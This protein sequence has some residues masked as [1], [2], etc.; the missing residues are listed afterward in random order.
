MNK[1]TY[2][3]TTPIYY[4]SNYLHIG[5]AYCT[6]AT[7][8]AARYKKLRGYDVKFLT[9]T[10]DHGQKIERT[11][12]E[13]GVTPMEYVDKIV[14][15]T[16]DLWKLMD[17]EYDYFRRTTDKDHEQAI[18]KI[19]KR[20]YDQGD[21][22]KGSYEGWY[23]T[24]CETF[25]TERQLVD[26]KCPD[27]GRGVEIVQ[28][29]CYFL[30]LSKY[31]DRLMK[32]IDDNPDFIQPVSRKNEMVNNFL[33]P[34][35]EDLCVSRTS[36]TWGVQVD[37]DPKHVVYVWVDALPNYITALGFSG[38]DESDFKKYWPA[39]VHF[40]GKEI[41]RFHTII[42]PIILM[43]LDLP[44]PKQV[45][46]HG[47]LTKDGQKIGKSM[48]NA[49]DPAAL[50]EKFGV[51]AIRYFLMREFTFGQDGN[52]TNEILM[53]RINS[54][55]ANDLGNLLSRTVGMIDRYFEGNLPKEQVITEF[56]ND[57]I[58]VAK[59]LPTKFE[60]HMEKLAFSDALNEVWAFI[61][62]ANKYIDETAPWAAIKDDM[63][64][65]QVAN[66]LYNLAEVLRISAILISPVM[67]NTPKA[68]YQQLN[69]VD[70]DL[71][72]WEAA[73]SFGLL[74][75]EIV[76][77]KGEIVFPR[78]DIKK[79]L[80]AWATTEASST[81]PLL[82]PK[83]NHLLSTPESTTANEITIDDFAKIEM[84]T[85]VVLECE[86]VKG[87]DKLLK[88][89]IK[90]G[91][92]TRQVVSGIAKFY[93]PEQMVGKKVVVVTNLK[94]VKLRGEMSYGM[95]LAASTKGDEMLNLVTVD[96]EIPDGAEVR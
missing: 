9:G 56:D 10:D 70:D 30:K 16:K 80:E 53:Q 78:L 76:I 82:E 96:G 59:A 22:Y 94:P 14:A 68:I 19:F 32:Y 28:E 15:A 23:C 40:V 11:A 74:G 88:S 20:L 45:F 44:L 86:F 35:L 77:T 81:E 3:V 42:W 13:H 2:Y 51:D 58:S 57:L 73:C 62:R 61:R 18:Q 24:P 5:N 6:V 1:P 33:K 37:F 66:V 36:I 55:L 46:G 39:D 25:F 21:I 67:P 84:K 89:Q 4:P 34:G 63:Q 47:W 93:T 8:V 85:G 90:I 41:V 31:A 43:A 27:C 65:P 17:I 95:I 48:G 75:K 72:T 50:I 49:I 69:I 54:D 71:K 26:K 7:D 83:Q 91:D 52:Y 38:D 12:K 87:S 29:E 92:E 64:K 60:R 79:E